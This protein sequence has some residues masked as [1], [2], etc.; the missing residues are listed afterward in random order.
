VHVLNSC[1][2]GM[3][4]HWELF[5]QEE[6]VTFMHGYQFLPSAV[7]ERNSFIYLYN[8]FL[9]NGSQYY[10]ILVRV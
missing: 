3:V 7:A 6:R 2:C 10:C 4:V 8:N 9:V 1:S 5:L